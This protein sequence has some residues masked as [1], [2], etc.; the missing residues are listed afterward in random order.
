MR[1]G[2]E[3]ARC[4]YRAGCRAPPALGPPNSSRKKIREKKKKHSGCV[5][6]GVVGTEQVEAAGRCAA[7]GVVANEAVPK[8]AEV[9][10]WQGDSG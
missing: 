8:G 9:F 1:A 7:S 4:R 3:G 6:S 10:E 2:G 5:T